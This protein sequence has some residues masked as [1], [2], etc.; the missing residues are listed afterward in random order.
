MSGTVQTPWVLK[1]PALR[2]LNWIGTILM[3]AE[4]AGLMLLSYVSTIENHD[5]H[6]L[7]FNIFITSAMLHM[8][9]STYLF[10]KSRRKGEMSSNEL[11]SYRY[12]VRP[13]VSLAYIALYT[14]MA[15][16]PLLSGG[17]APPRLCATA[18][19]RVHCISTGATTSTASHTVCPLP[20]MACARTCRVYNSTRRLACSVQL[21]LRPGMVDSLYQHHISL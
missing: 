9:A 11:L 19:S 6:V 21:L 4:Y 8:V 13:L 20:D 3:A 14:H 15:C 2:A 5:V 18:S 12:V 7:G 10:A 16:L 1:R 17:S